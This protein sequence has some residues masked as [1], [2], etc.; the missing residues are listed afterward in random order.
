[1]RTDDA[2]NTGVLIGGWSG[3]GGEGDCGGLWWWRWSGNYDHHTRRGFIQE[4]GFLAP[5]MKNPESSNWNPE[6][7]TA[8]DLLT[9]QREIPIYNVI[10]SILVDFLLCRL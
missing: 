9:N 2:P 10:L 6:S 5:L 7:K 3:G 4:S 1:M 8:N